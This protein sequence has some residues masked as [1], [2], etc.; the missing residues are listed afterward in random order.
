M[1]VV[2]EYSDGVVEIVME[3]K[4]E[5]RFWVCVFRVVDD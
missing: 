3:L 5:L 1:V 4:F 2:N